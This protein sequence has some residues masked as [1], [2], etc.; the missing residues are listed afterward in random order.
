VGRSIIDGGNG[1]SMEASGSSEMRTRKDIV[2][3][4]TAVFVP[5]LLTAIFDGVGAV[6]LKGRF[7]YLWYI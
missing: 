5:Y 6:N 3:S 7:V 1:L 2:T 4:Q